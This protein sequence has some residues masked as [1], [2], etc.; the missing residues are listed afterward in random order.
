MINMIK[1][2]FVPHACCW[3]HGRGQ[4]QALLAVC[5]KCLYFPFYIYLPFTHRSDSASGQIRV[6]D[7]RGDDKPLF[8][9]DKVHRA[10][11]HI[12][13]VSSRQL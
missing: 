11:V 13:T 2:N 12:M 3:V 4:A 9:V 5:V 10:P 1:L 8:V 7:G 6:Y